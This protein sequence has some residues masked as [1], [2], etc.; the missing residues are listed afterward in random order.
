MTVKTIVEMDIQAEADKINRLAILM[1]E[2][3]RLDDFIK[4]AYDREYQKQLIKE[5]NIE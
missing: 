4:S 2:D 5:Y 3:N 1:Y